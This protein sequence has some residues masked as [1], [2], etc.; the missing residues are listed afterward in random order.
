MTELKE[1]LLDKY[2]YVDGKKFIGQLVKKKECQYE[3]TT[4]FKRKTK[5]EYISIYD[6]KQKNGQR[7]ITPL[8]QVPGDEFILI[9]D[10]APLGKNIERNFEETY[11]NKLVLNSVNKYKYL[12]LKILSGIYFD[13]ETKFI[14]ED[15]NGDII[16]ISINDAEKYFSVNSFNALEKEIF[17]LGKYMIVI[18]PN[19]GL[20]DSSGLDEIKINSPNETILFE[21]KEELN[22]FLSLNKNIS[23]ENYKLLGNMMIKNHFYEK[24]IYY[25][26]Y[27][28]KLNKN[29]NDENL[30]IKLYSNLS[31]AYIKY[32]YYTKTIENADL[33]LNVINELM[34]NN[35]KD[36]TLRLQKLRILYRKLKALVILRK[37]PEANEILFNKS[38]NNPNKDI[39]ED[40]LKLAQVKELLEK[41]KIGYKNTLGIYDYIKMIKEEQNNLELDSYGDYLNPKIEIKYEK[42]KGIKMTAKEKINIGELLIVEKSLSFSKNNNYDDDIEDKTVSKDNPKVIVEIEMF[43]KLC[44]K[45]KKAPLD[46]EKFYYLFDGKNLDQDLNERK[47]Y[48]EEQDKGLRNLEHFKINQAICLN[49]YGLG[50][51]ILFYKES[52][53]GV[54]GYASF[55][56]HD[57]LPNTEHFGIGDYYFGYCIRGIDKGEEITTRYVLASESYQERQ[58]TILENWRFNC[59]CQLCQYQAKKND[60]QYDSYMKLFDKPY[61]EIPQKNADSLEEYL[62]KNKKK[63]SCYEIANAYLKLQDYYYNKRIF[64]K[65]KKCSELITK[66]ADGKNY[67]FQLNN[68][69]KKLLCATHS[70]SN[71]F[72]IVYGDIIGYLEK[73]TP[74]NSEVIQ[75]LFRSVSNCFA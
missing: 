30:D 14:C 46:Y 59:K 3:K 10:L 54:W 48:C 22:N 23:P 4:N 62:E 35:E 44:L 13:K 28:L 67:N 37:F 75:Y 68:L 74:L 25:Y 72:L 11:I 53:V 19:Y 57:C 43:N 52:G 29:K 71:E 65:A 50:R 12:I 60:F 64:N 56:N 49:K 73:Y 45:L 38:E 6:S 41:V 9:D 40:F 21:D 32:G 63:Y 26:T 24:A 2:L 51:D 66:Y 16:N 31:E 18:E 20:F 15:M 47:K 36:N 1:G 55:F 58:K 39:M 27:A 17:K 34:K 42:G 33:C 69:Y 7:S 61:N 8:K 5:E 70:K